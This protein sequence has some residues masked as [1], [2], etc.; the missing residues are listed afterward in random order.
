MVLLRCYYGIAPMWVAQP[1]DIQ[2]LAK[3]SEAVRH[4]PI[5]R[6]PLPADMRNPLAH[7]MLR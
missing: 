4:D 5:P 1:I 7:S 3:A 2:R 6:E